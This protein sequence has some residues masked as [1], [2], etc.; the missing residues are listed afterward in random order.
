M[1]GSPTAQAHFAILCV[2][3][4]FGYAYVLQVHM[5]LQ[6]GIDYGRGRVRSGAGCP[7]SES[8]GAKVHN[9]FNNYSAITLQI[10]LSDG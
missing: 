5:L 7:P 9:T 1:R 8:S 10:L 4:A 6:V 3:V 2:F